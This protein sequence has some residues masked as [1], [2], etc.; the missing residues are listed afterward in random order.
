MG[1][2]LYFL[3]KQAREMSIIVKRS[4]FV[5]CKKKK[6][7]LNKKSYKNPNGQND[8]GDIMWWFLKQT[9]LE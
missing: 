2:F 9:S 8:D 6:F 7:R 3:N 1:W 4:F 5:T